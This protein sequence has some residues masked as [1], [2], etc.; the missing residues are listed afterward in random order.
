MFLRPVS[1]LGATLQRGQAGHNYQGNNQTQ[2]VDREPHPV[3]RSVFADGNLYS[4]DN[5]ADINRQH[6]DD[7]HE[8]EYQSHG[9]FGLHFFYS[10]LSRTVLTCS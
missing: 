1:A 10:L 8:N 5:Q 6:R 2:R 3:R 4:Q 7:N 9:I